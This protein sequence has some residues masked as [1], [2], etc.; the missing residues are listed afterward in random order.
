MKEEFWQER[1]AS[2]RMAFH[3]DAPNRFLR[4]HFSVL[5]VAPQSHVFV[6]LC[7]KSTDLDWILDQGH[8][9]TGIE[10]NG[11]AV[12]A[13]FARRA[14][15]PQITRVS[16]LRRLSAGRLTL[17]QGDFFALNEIDLGPVDAVYDR[18]AL[19]ALPQNLREAYAT[20]LPALTGTAQQLVVSYSYDQ[21]QTDGPPFSV[22]E[23]E[24]RRFYA[25]HFNV[26]LLASEDITGPLATRCAG[27][28]QVWKLAPLRY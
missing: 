11:A 26:D 4:T 24:I 8:R 27:K 13:V 21:S 15:I 17:W 2:G 9:V 5:D 22:P 16:D 7:G 1:W 23:A 14:L 28:E 3:E 19:V 18:A 25:D 20:R 6:P 10:F 12:D